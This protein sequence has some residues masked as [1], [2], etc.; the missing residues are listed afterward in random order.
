[1]KEGIKKG[2]REEGRKEGNGESGMP[3]T[4]SSQPL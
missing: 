3:K 2:G 4:Q 1:M